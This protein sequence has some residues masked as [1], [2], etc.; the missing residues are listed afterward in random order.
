MQKDSSDNPATGQDAVI[1]FVSE[2]KIFPC[3]REQKDD[4]HCAWLAK[5]GAPDQILKL[6][7]IRGIRNAYL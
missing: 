2:M 5:C 3:W 1:V 4:G 6:I 7:L